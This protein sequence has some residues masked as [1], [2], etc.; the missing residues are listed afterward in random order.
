MKTFKITRSD[1]FVNF[2][3]HFFIR[4]IANRRGRNSRTLDYRDKFPNSSL[5][6]EPTLAR[7]SAYVTVPICSDSGTDTHLPTNHLPGFFRVQDSKECI[8][9]VIDFWNLYICIRWICMLQWIFFPSRVIFS[10]WKRRII[11]RGWL[12]SAN[13][14]MMERWNGIVEYTEYSKTR[15]IR[16]ILKHGIYGSV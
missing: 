6:W 1:L 9:E 10:T 13:G 14:G 5:Y 4:K 2:L 8:I 12:Y 16:N 3:N 7:D 11:T 15:N